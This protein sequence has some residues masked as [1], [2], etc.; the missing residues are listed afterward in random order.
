MLILFIYLFIY[1]NV[2]LFFTYDSYLTTFL[3]WM[4]DDN[5]CCCRRETISSSNGRTI[6]CVW[7]DI[8]REQ[9]E[10]HTL[11]LGGKLLWPTIWEQCL[12]NLCCKFWSDFHLKK[13]KKSD[14][15]SMKIHHL[16]EVPFYI[17][18]IT[19]YI[20]KFCPFIKPLRALVHKRLIYLLFFKFFL[21]N[22][23]ILFL[24]FL[25]GDC[26]CR[27]FGINGIFGLSQGVSW[28][29]SFGCYINW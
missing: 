11:P 27:H 3:N 13:L 4:L 17:R 7:D 28:F 22:C 5:F 23:A 1:S 12:Q 29:K 14:F 19:L 21:T 26:I 2:I 25:P 9:G 24:F 10:L 18:T 15:G 20:H 8:P 6:W 16:T